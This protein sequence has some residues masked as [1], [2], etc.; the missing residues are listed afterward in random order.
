MEAEKEVFGSINKYYEASRQSQ[1][2]AQPQSH[3]GTHK[4]VEQYASLFKARS[5]ETQSASTIYRE[6]HDPHIVIENSAATTTQAVGLSTTSK[7]TSKW[8]IKFW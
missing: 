6:S 3:V 1:V 5:N 4:R 2:Q 7:P 8:K